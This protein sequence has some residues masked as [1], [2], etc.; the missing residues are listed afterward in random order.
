MVAV[1]GTTAHAGQVSRYLGRNTSVA[2]AGTPEEVVSYPATSE[3]FSCDADSDLG[4]RAVKLTRRDFAF[5]PADSDTAAACGV[6]FQPVEFKDGVF[7]PAV[8]KAKAG[9]VKGDS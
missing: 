8:A 9:A 6:E 2:N 7:V 1:P 4:R 3:G 5:W